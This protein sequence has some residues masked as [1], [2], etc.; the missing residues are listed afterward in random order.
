LKREKD[1]MTAQQI[2][3]YLLMQENQRQKMRD[4]YVGMPV[5]W[6]RDL[7]RIVK[8]SSEKIHEFLNSIEKV[9]M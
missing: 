2:G 6:K 3:E 7:L 8:S 5:K 1:I 4:I 9:G